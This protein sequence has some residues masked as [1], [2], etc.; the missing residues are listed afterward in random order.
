MKKKSIY[1]FKQSD[2]LII[3]FFKEVVIGFA[4]YRGKEKQQRVGRVEYIPFQILSLH[5]LCL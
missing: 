2:L 5:V 4:Y 1:E 3:V